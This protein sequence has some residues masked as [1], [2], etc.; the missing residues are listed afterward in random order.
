MKLN[1]FSIPPADV[2]S[3]KEKLTKSRMEV[4]KEVDQDGWHGEFYFSTQAALVDIPWVETYRS[5]FDSQN[6]PPR[7]K[8]YYAAFLF[9]RRSRCFALSYGKSH[10]YLRPYCDYDFGVELAKRIANE[11]EIKQTSSRRFQG[12]R[13]KDIRSFAPNTRLDVESGESIDYLQAAIIQSRAGTFGATGKF[14]TSALVSPDITPSALGCFLSKVEAEVATDPLFTLPRTLVITEESEIAR[15]DA[16]LIDELTTPMGT[17]EFTHNSYDL[18]G[19]DFVFSTNGSFKLRCPGYPTE[20]FEEL[21]I[22][23]LKEYIEANGLSRGDVVRIKIVHQHEGRP[24]YTQEVKQALDFIADDD[25]VLLSN[26]RWMR[27]N[28]DY[29]QFLDEYLESILVEE[30]EPAFRRITTTEPQ[31]NQSAEIHQAGYETADKDFS[32]FRTRSST[33]IEAWDLKKGSCVYAVKFGTAQK[34]GYVCDQATAVL[35]LIRNRAGVTQV[36]GFQ[37]YCLW[38]GYESKAELK[39]ITKSGSIILK[40]KIETWARKALELGIEPMLKIS[41]KTA[42]ASST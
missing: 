6:P 17:T 29:L 25:R 26:G 3:L 38:L 39:D 33:P 4:I 2:A 13:K 24:R 35:E 18:Y 28:Q 37:R 8:N 5:Y 30:P 22:Q 40:Q 31:F 41:H 9:T 32:I 21:D 27:F 16:K 15:Y 42:R 20:E 1:V 19:V 14:G 23:D 12:K 10:F 11:F 34:L 7:N 36:P